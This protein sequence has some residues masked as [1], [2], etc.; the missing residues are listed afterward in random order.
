MLHLLHLESLDSS[1]RRDLDF[2]AQFARLRA[3]ALDFLNKII[4]F[5]DFAK[6][7]VRAIQPTSDDGGDKELRA[8]GVLS[9]VRHREEA[10]LCVLE[11]EVLI[12][13]FLAVDRFSTSAVASG[14]ITTLK[15]ELGDDTMECGVGVAKAVLAR[16][17]LAEILRGL[18]YDIVVQL[19]DD[20]ACVGAADADVEVYVRLRHGFESE[21]ASTAGEGEEFPRALHGRSRLW[22]RQLHV[23]SRHPQVHASGWRFHQRRRHWWKIDL[24]REIRR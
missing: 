24:R 16:A 14:E 23:P 11:L 15:H 22:L 1:R 19:E 13:E 17:E 12:C 9:G 3:Q 20:A 2:L 4:V 6:H 8:V 7:D 10:G 5:D 21:Q 18:G